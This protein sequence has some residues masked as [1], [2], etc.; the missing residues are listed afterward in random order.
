MNRDWFLNLWL[1]IGIK[2]GF[3]SLAYCATHDECNEAND[4]CQLAVSIL[5]S[6]PYQGDIDET[7]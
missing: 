1:M 3:V 6:N 7:S 2:L 5:I 4:P